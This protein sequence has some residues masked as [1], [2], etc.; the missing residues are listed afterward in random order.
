MPVDLSRRN[1]YK[2]VLS[3]VP[4]QSVWTLVRLHIH[5]CPGVSA[6]VVWLADCSLH[7]SAFLLMCPPFRL[8]PLSALLHNCLPVCGSA[9]PSPCPS[10]GCIW[11]Q[12]TSLTP[13]PASQ[14]PPWFNSSPS[15]GAYELMKQK[16][17]KKK[18]SRLQY[19]LNPLFKYSSH[20]HTS[21]HTH[22]AFR[23]YRYTQLDLKKHT[24]DAPLSLPSHTHTFF[25]V[26][27]TKEEKACFLK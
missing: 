5:S 19:L 15:S 16:K 13:T 20:R 4:V 17:K 9:R 26:T 2:S 6:L 8:T 7:L 18:K 1:T 3:F 24:Q 14:I 25:L 21:T 27:P 23:A 12:Q 10:A 22:T 11:M